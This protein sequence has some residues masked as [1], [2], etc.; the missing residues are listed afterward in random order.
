V[1]AGM[2]AYL[3][4]LAGWL[5][6]SIALVDAAALAATLGALLTISKVLSL[7]RRRVVSA[8]ASRP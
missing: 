6:A 5:A 4:A 3:A 8:K 2:P 1:I 7:L